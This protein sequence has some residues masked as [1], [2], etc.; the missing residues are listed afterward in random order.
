EL[1][2]GM[3]SGIPYDATQYIEDALSE[4]FKTLLET[5][6]IV[7]VVI[8]LFIGSLRSVLVPVIAIPL[9]LIGATALMLLVGF[10]LNLLTLLAIVLA[11]GLVVDDAIV[12]LENIER[13]VREGMPPFQ[14]AIQGARELVTPIIAITITLAAVYAPIGL[15]GGLTG[16][17]FREFAFTL[18]G[19][20]L[21]SGVVALTLSPMMSSKLIKAGHEPTKLEARLNN[22]F[23]RLK[24]RYAALLAASLRQRGAVLM[25][26]ALIVPCIL[27]FYIFSVKEIAPRE[28]QGVI[29]SIIQASP[30]SSLEQTT[31]F[32]EEVSKVYKSFPEYAGT[33]Q[34]TQPTFGFSGIVTKPWSERSRT[35]LEMEPEAWAKMSVIPGLRMIV[36]TPPPLPGGSDFPVEFIISST[37]EPR[38][39]YELAG[40]LV[41]KAFESGLFMFADTDLKFDQ[42]QAQI[43]L[44]RDRINASGLTLASVGSDLWVLLGGDYVNR[45]SI[46]GRS[47]KVIPQVKRGRRLTPEQLLS[48]YVS[49]NQS[50]QLVPLASFATIEETVEPRQLNRFQQ[51]NSAKIQASPA[52]GVSIDQALSFLEEES[53][54]LLPKGFLLDYAGESRQLRKE[55]SALVVTLMLSFVVIFLVLAAQFESFRD[56]FIILLGSVPLGLAGA[57]LFVFLGFTS[58]NIYSQ[59]GLIT[60]VGLVAK[61]GILI[62]EFANILRERG[63]PKLEAIQQA[64]CTRLRPVLMTSVATVAGH[65]P[66]I[67]A[68]GA[69]AGARNSIGAVLVTGMTIGTLFTLLVVPSIYMLVS[70]D[71]EHQPESALAR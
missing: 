43:I 1:P 69:G 10:S 34:L 33:F 26:A 5:V 24:E 55:G 2:A 62:V 29:F 18:A 54:N 50:G 66:L 35:T 56:P 59:V 38:Q 40:A 52:E 63:L 27:P 57:L 22:F 44:D 39:V 64:A 8:Y 47:Y 46:Q 15:Q 16:A 3:Q 53:R 13:H 21:I 58:I 60:L 68:S 31:I 36:T 25:V 14:A 9:S 37:A 6:A 49:G 20:V 45:F 48:H 7:I 71:S 23:E 61:N 65:F 19:A 11:V 28:D 51:L 30:D 67:L 4:V 17:L 12:I 41:G 70:S 42:P 32:A